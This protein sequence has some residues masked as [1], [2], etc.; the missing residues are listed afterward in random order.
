[1]EGEREG[2][3]EVSKDEAVRVVAVGAQQHEQARM[4]VLVVELESCRIFHKTARLVGF[5]VW[6]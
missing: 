6:R 5:G 3:H 2:D 4:S 1:M